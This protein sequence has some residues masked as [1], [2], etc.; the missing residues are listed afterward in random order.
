MTLATLPPTRMYH[1]TCVDHGKPGIDKDGVVKP[2]PTIGL[3][4]FTDLD[5][6]HVSSLGLTDHLL[7]CDRT[8]VRYEVDPEDVTPW[9]DV[10]RTAALPSVLRVGLESCPGA[11]PR[12]WFVSTSPVAVLP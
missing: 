9:M 10:R 7:D 8:K 4:W 11:M 2:H 6:P 12:H 5:V 3:A 1:Y